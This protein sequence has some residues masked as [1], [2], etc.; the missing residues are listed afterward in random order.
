[1]MSPKSPHHIQTHH[2]FHHLWYQYPQK[3]LFI[4]WAG[5]LLDMIIFHLFSITSTNSPIIF[6]ELFSHHMNIL[7]IFR[8]KQH[9]FSHSCTYSYI[10]SKHLSDQSISHH[11][12][13]NGGKVSA[14]FIPLFSISAI[15]HNCFP[16]ISIFHIS[17]HLFFSIAEISPSRAPSFARWVA[18]WALTPRLVVSASAELRVVDGGHGLLLGSEDPGK[19]VDFSRFPGFH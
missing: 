3:I 7:I 10:F 19:M 16:T 9:V 5:F 12:P 8:Q 6:V 18:R 13:I 15:F 17:S 11:I 2:F 14:I 1:M 4:F